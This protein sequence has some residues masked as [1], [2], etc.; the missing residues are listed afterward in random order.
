MNGS[1]G[2]EYSSVGVG[3]N[4]RLCMDTKALPRTV[5]SQER[6]EMV[7]SGNAV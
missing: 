3:R 7:A 5:R 1:N 2:V 4:F 6:Q